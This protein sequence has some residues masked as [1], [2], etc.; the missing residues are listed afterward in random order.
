MSDRQQAKALKSLDKIDAS[1]RRI[2]KNSILLEAA[3]A[4]DRALLHRAAEMLKALDDYYDLVDGVCF[5]CHRW[6]HEGHRRDCALD[7]LI[8]ELE[9]R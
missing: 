9:Q 6:S 3:R 1:M 5:K 2:E 8:R 7:A 4:A